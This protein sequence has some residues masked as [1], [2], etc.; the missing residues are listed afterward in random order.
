[1]NPYTL[2]A[3]RGADSDQGAASA[4]RRHHHPQVNQ[5]SHFT[6]NC[7]SDFAFDFTVDLTLDFTLDF[8]VNFTL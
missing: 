8:T 4:G 7:T 5:I 6:L 1:M 2:N 3:G